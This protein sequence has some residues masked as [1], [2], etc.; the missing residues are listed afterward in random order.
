[1]DEEAATSHLSGGS[2]VQGSDP[3]YGGLINDPASAKGAV[4]L[5][6]NA[7]LAAIVKE[8]LVKVQRVHLTL[9]HVWVDPAQEWV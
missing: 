1:M 6:N 4:C 3:A 2:S 8:V 7:I 5:H 9:D